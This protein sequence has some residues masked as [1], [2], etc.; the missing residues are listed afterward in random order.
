VSRDLELRPASDLLALRYGQAAGAAQLTGIQALV[1]L[2]LEARRS[3]E[4]NGLRTAAYVSGYEGSPLGG[5]DLE[6]ARLGGLLTELGITFRPAVN[7]ELAATAIMGTQLAA[8]RPDAVVNG[9]T[10]FWYGKSP[11]LDRACDALRHANLVGSH[12]DGGA[13]ALVGDDTA[14][15]SSTI[16]GASEAILADLGMPV[17]YPSDSQD[18]LDLGMHA[19]AMSRSSGL[20][21]ALKIVTGVADGASAAEL[22]PDRVRPASPGATGP[23]SWRHTPDARL[24]QPTISALEQSMCGIRLDRALAYAADHKLDTITTPAGAP[25]RVGVIAAGYTYQSAQHSLRRLGI[26]NA[27]AARRGLRVLKL[28]VIHPLVPSVISE[29]AAGLDEI[30]VIEDKRGLIEAGVAAILYGQGHRPRLCGKRD[31]DGREL[32]PAH[33][34]LDA[35]QITT[36]LARRLSAIGDFP[37]VRQFLA[38]AD[39]PGR[40]TFLTL[41]PRTPYFCS[42]CPHNTSTQAPGGALVGAGIGCHALALTVPTQRSGDI[43]GLSQMGGEG[44]SWIG[45]EPYVS[46]SHLFQNIGDGTFFHSGSLA[47]RA[48]VAARINITYKLLFNSA[49]AMTGGQQAQGA[50]NV[51]DLCR[52]LLAEGAS[53]IVVTAPEPRTVAYRRQLPPGVSIADREQLL[54]V[55]QRLARVPGVTVLIHDQECATELRRKRK[56][57]LVASPSTRA[58]INERVCEG[59]G[60]CGSRSNCLSLQPANSP[61]GRKTRIDQSSCNLDFSCIDGDCPSFI[62]VKPG[63]KKEPPSLGMLPSGNSGRTI[64]LQREFHIRITGIGGTGVV[65]LSQILTRAASIAGFHVRSLDQTGL[66]QKG[67][68]VVSDVRF[69]PDPV[70]GNRGVAADCDLYLGCDA[71]VAADPRNLAVADAE[72]TAAVVSLSPVATGPMVLDHSQELPDP[73]AIQ[74]LI[75]A[76]TRS[77]AARF[78]DARRAASTLVGHDQFANLLLAGVAFESQALPIPPEAIEAAIRDNGTESDRNITAFRCGRLAVADP[79][80]F[81]A[82]ERGP[83]VTRARAGRSLAGPARQHLGPD[84]PEDL[85]E[86]V[87][88][89]AGELVSYQH[90]AYANRYLAAVADVFRRD[91]GHESVPAI[92]TAVARHLYTLMAYKDEYEVARL[93]LDPAMTDAVEREFGAGAKV[94]YRLHPPVL[95]ALGMKRKVTF[96]PWFRHVFRLLAALRRL[97]GTP[98]DVFGYTGLRR[99]ERLLAAEYLR[100]VGLALAGLGSGCTYA[101]ALDVAESAAVIRGYESIKLDSIARFRA[102]ARGLPSQPPG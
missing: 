28:A 78:L 38:R 42:G 2:V 92:T 71:L 82:A 31:P 36:T 77:G 8:G 46:A 12:P 81:A 7:E 23:G 79:A 90:R 25:A 63:K 9:V 86:L 17:L 67:G 20:W 40:G 75:E 47:L 48:A 54:E 88:H 49:V 30:I 60:D 10:G 100:E 22:G 57:G 80:R 101:Q 43:V 52:L 97:R 53:Q 98:L 66:A 21:V 3:D 33:G 15:K 83:A 87:A 95:R 50:R 39:P 69:G 45:M 85:L 65:T 13:I 29:F 59:C 24:L 37:T 34:E 102:A 4:R 56:R 72:R 11:G 5:F 55:Q 61:F 99:T 1:R 18:V 64:D 19:V 91:P 73:A 41:T 51:P 16:P 96:G 93:S 58:M 74:A 94:S 70:A 76:R 68:P 89:R 44:A 84:A 26:D 32:F 62:S 27:E 14:A 35:D 6:L